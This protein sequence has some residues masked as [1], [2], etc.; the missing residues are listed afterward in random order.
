MKKRSSVFFV[1]CIMFLLT[2][3]FSCSTDFWSDTKEQ[4]SKSEVND[5]QV[6]NDKELDAFEQMQ[7][8]LSSA[9]RAGK[10][11]SSNSNLIEDAE[12]KFDIALNNFTQKHSLYSDLSTNEKTNLSIDNNSYDLISSDPKK[13]MNFIKLNKT[14]EF[15]QICSNFVYRNKIDIDANDIINDNKLKLNEKISLLTMLHALQ[16]NSVSCTRANLMTRSSLSPESG[17][18]YKSKSQR[19]QDEYHTAVVLCNA[20]Y[21]L[22]LAIVVATG[23]GT[24]GVGAVVSTGLACYDY[25]QCQNEALEQYRN[26]IK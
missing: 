2:V 9:T 24:G 13:I 10:M 12:D 23:V 1:F 16:S 8:A 4:S 20:R 18:N 22:D 25:S 7:G 14:E 26:C 3:F 19:C 11:S 15:Y 21:A 17:S 5:L 6:F